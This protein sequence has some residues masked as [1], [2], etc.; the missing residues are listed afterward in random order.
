MRLVKQSWALF[1]TLFLLCQAASAH[2]LSNGYISLKAESESTFSGAILLQPFD[3]HQALGLDTNNDNQLTW[4]EAQSQTDSIQRYAYEH[5]Q[6]TADKK[7][8]QPGT[9]ALE[10]HRVSGQ[11]LIYIP[12]TFTC[13]ASNNLALAYSGI[14]LQDPSHKLLFTFS[15]LQN[16]FTQVLTTQ[17]N[18]VALDLAS[19]STLTTIK[20]FVYE[21]II[22]IWIGIDHILF[23]IATLLTVNLCRHK[24]KWNPEHSRK[25]IIKQTVYLVT[26]FTLAHSLTLTSTA[27]GWYTPSSRWVELGIAISVLL[28]ALNNIWPLVRRLGFITFAFGLL[29]GMGFASVF[30]EL[31]STATKPL[32]TI[33]SFNI[34]VEIG[35]LVIVAVLLPILLSLRFVRLYAKLIMPITSAA[36]AVIAINWA[37][38]RW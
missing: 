13:P 16:T 17:D 38:Q 24:H 35:Q 33:A 36:I 6:L 7:L 2:E 31:Q 5:V 15:N 26:A 30:A 14:F 23:L 3:L 29:H 8:C 20:N 10:L 28:T 18:K 11:Q 1:F 32:L 21:G 19:Q 9:N 37:I 34:G 12:L 4:Q 27:L 25:E 22:H